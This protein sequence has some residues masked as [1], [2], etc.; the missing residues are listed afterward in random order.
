MSL[1]RRQWYE[2]IK[3]LE[4]DK[5]LDESKLLLESEKGSQEWWVERLQG[6]VP[7]EY[8]QYLAWILANLYVG[9]GMN[10]I[11]LQTIKDMLKGLDMDGMKEDIEDIARR[12]L[13]GETITPTVLPPVD[14]NIVPTAPPTPIKPVPDS[15]P[16]AGPT[17]WPKY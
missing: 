8:L 15:N 9:D 16:P 4:V 14:P 5:Q 17:S 1:Q 2:N 10:H 7:D 13:D 11:E 6:L 3:G 12:L